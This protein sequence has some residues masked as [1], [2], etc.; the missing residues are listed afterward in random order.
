VTT[1]AFTLATTRYAL[2]PQFFPWVP[3]EPIERRPLLGL[4]EVDSP[5]AFYYL[6][7]GTFALVVA[8]VLGIRNSRTGR[9]L[10]ALRENERAAAAFGISVVRAKLTAFALSGFLA[11]VAGAL[12]V[13]QNGRFTLGLFPEE[14]NLVVFTAAVVGGI[15]SV[16]G[17][18]IG[19]LFLKGGEWFLSDV[20]QLFASS[21]GVL[22][23]LLVLPGGLGGWL[24]RARDLW[25][26]WVAR[27]QDIVVPSL[28]ADV[29]RLGE[30]QATTRDGRET[31]DGEG[32][33]ADGAGEDVVAG[34]GRQ[35]VR[36]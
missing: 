30:A 23:V 19:A 9:V 29:G 34:Q 17:A 8:G 18:A 36:R 2:N 4:W 5:T 16:T 6:A 25:L 1:L 7:L 21:V 35:M 31:G 3:V 13:T 14:D 12:L 27:R 32:E 11:S 10:L 24:F 15:G 33:G 22:I 20:W 28:L 26:R